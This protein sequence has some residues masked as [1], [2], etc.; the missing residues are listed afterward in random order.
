MGINTFLL[1]AGGIFGIVCLLQLV[2]VI[3]RMPVRI[4][5]VDIPQY[6]SALAVVITGALCY[7]A[8]HLATV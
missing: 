4:A 3:F 1:V 7:W 6:V 2:R 5:S 8:M